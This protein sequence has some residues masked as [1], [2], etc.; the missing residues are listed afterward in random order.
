MCES[1]LKTHTKDR[2]YKDRNIDVNVAKTLTTK[3]E[4]T[5]KG[6]QK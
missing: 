6:P 4:C 1:G 5:M 3:T 2:I